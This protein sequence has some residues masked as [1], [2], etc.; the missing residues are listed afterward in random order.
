MA[1]VN[2]SQDLS[3][4]LALV[5]EDL[6]RAAERSGRDPGEV[7]LVAVTKGHPIEVVNAALEAGLTDL[8]ENRVEA[9][10]ERLRQVSPGRC[11]WHMVGRL[12]R[13]QAP[14]L[15]GRVELLHSL[16][17]VRLAERLE[18]TWDSGAPVLRVLI[19]VNVSRESSKTGFTPENVVEGVG[20]IL[21]MKSL[22][23]QGLMTMAPLSDDPRVLRDSFRSLRR[24]G[25]RL[26]VELSAWEG[27]ELSMGMSNDFTL[28]VEEGSTMVRLGTALFGARAG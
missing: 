8:G 15:R 10:E 27:R 12:Q 21:E 24:V 23:P 14:W 16:D 17:S 1:A 26:E 2:S 9:L 18:R 4:N 13:R 19:Q 28:A 7:H 25:E 22:Q 20:R 11:R 3:R 5:R 6:A